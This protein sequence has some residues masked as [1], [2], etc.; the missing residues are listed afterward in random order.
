MLQL[1][2]SEYV[3]LISFFS[4]F[5]V[6]EKIRWIFGY[7]CTKSHQTIKSVPFSPLLFV[8]SLSPLCLSPL[9]PSLPF[10]VIFCPPSCPSSPTPLSASQFEQIVEY[11]TEGFTGHRNL[12]GWK[13]DFDRYC[14]PQL[15]V[16]FIAQFEQF[17]LQHI[18]I[19][20][21]LDEIQVPSPPPPHL[22][23][24]ALPPLWF[25]VPDSSV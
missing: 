1:S 10:L 21:G 2:F 8:P 20:W 3:H 22:P 24:P 14:H 5:G 17:I 19:L 16:M 4:V 25:P 6:H 11:L 13:K 12:L 15:K 18:R 7:M 9:L 23:N